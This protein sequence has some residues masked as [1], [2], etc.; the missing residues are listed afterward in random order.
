MAEYSKMECLGSAVLGMVFKKHPLPTG[1]V[2]TQ[3]R[4]CR[5]ETD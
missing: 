5:H 1:G 2:D 4:L 3:W